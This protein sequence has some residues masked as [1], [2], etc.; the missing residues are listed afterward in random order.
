MRRRPRQSA[1]TVRTQRSAKAFAFGV[2]TGV[3]ITFDAHRAEDLVEGLA[4]LRVAIVNEE[5]DGVLATELH[6]EVARL[7]G[8]PAPDRV[9]AAGDVFDPPS[10]ERD[11]EEDV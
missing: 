4:E 7:L 1:R 3:R 9:R 5:P 6:D 8:D 10:C 2:W 11:E